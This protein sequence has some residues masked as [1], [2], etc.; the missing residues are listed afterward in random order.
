MLKRFIHWIRPHKECKQCCLTCPYFKDCI[1]D[2][3]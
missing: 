3:Q 2:F 1:K